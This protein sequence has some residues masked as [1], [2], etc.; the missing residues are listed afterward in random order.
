MTLDQEQRILRICDKEA[1]IQLMNRHSYYYSNDERQEE[2]DQIWVQSDAFRQTASLGYNNGYHVGFEEIRNHY[3]R[4]R[5]QLLKQ[6]QADY[7]GHAPH[8]GFGG[9]QMHTS[10]TPLVYIADDGQSAKYQGYQLGYQSIGSGKD[11]GVSYFEFG[12][13]YADL[14]LENGSWKI[15]HLVLEHDHT[16]EV[17]TS[18]A[19]VPVRRPDCEDPLAI[20]YGNPTILQTVYNPMFGWEYIWQDMP[21]PYTS[22]EDGFSYGPNGMLGKPYY[23]RERR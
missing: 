7:Q 4:G 6:R 17:G 2:L 22:Y 14:V 3:V 11:S 8:P 1:C 23:E 15:W 21:R 12:L 16:V 13:I 9:S 19:Q 10:T 20:D 5:Q 18:Y